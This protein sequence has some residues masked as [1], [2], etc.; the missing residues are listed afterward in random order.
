[1][2]YEDDPLAAYRRSARHPTYRAGPPKLGGAGIAGRDLGRRWGPPRRNRRRLLVIGGVAVVVGVAGLFAWRHL[3]GSVRIEG[4]D[5]GA[6]LGR[7]AIDGREVRVEVS[8]GGAPRAKLNGTPIGDP[9][10]D[11]AEYVWHLPNL[12]DGA[13]HFEVSADGGLFGSA[14]HT[15]SFTVDS[16][17]PVLHLPAAVPAVA[18][19]QPVT[20]DG[21]VDERVN[22]TA[23]GASV[24]WSDRTFHLHFAHPPTAPVT[25]TAT[26]AAG[27]TTT[28]T[29]IVPVARPNVRGVHVT[30]LAWADAQLHTEIISMIDAKQINAVELDLKDESG[31]VG[32]DS[33]VPLAREIGATQPSY[34]LR[35]AVDDLHARGIR[36]IGRVVAFRD[37][38]LADAAWKKGD[39]DWVVQNAAGGPLGA[40]GG[41]ANFANPDVQAYNLA[42]AQE[43]AR[44]GVD[45]IL[46]DYVRRPEGPLS[47]MVFP[48]LEG[49]VADAISGFLAKGQA[50]LRPLKALQGASVFGIAATRPDQIGQDVGQIAL[51]TDYVAPMLYPSHWNKG[52]YGVA[53]PNR[54]PYDIIK[55]SLADFVAEVGPTG[56]VVAPWLQDFDDGVHYGDAEVLA[57]IQAAKDLGIDSW[58]LWNPSTVYTASALQPLG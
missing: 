38:I 22:V 45:E 57:Q 28:T 23:D 15:V 42:I 50:M 53:D 37:P 48:G 49:S 32:Y 4:L 26:D 20:V 39:T 29:V 9:A 36:V 2:T 13:Y 31:V 27:N 25:V 46:W 3:S 33:A 47:S 40:Y 35:A 52:E 8:R 5:D 56:R 18:I 44:A 54:Q 24:D 21:S 30:A 43:A 41:F 17:A 58:L 10:R 51:H 34:S 1:M 55:A 11:G 7:N 6:S 16:V 12:V 14:R 19:D